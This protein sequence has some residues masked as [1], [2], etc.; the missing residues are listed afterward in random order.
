VIG[1]ER[2]AEAIASARAGTLVDPHLGATVVMEVPF[3]EEGG[4]LL[5]SGPGIESAA[6]LAVGPDRCWVEARAAK[7]AEF[8]LGVD[9]I[10]VDSRFALAALPRTT[11]IREVS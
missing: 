4:T 6:R 5:L 2:A 10:L 1:M 7:N 3:L 11:V 9:L 8:P